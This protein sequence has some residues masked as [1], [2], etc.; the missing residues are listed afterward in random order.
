VKFLYLRHGKTEFSLNNQ[1]MGRCNLP[2][3][4]IDSDEFTDAINLIEEWKPTKVLY[5]PLLRAVETK[6]I[7]LSAIDITQSF[8]CSYL[9]ERDFGSLEGA[10]KNEQNRMR[11][12]SC[13]RAESKSQFRQ[14]IL[15]FLDIIKSET[16]SSILLIGHS[17]FYREMM[18]IINS[19]N[20]GVIDC[21][22]VKEVEFVNI[23]SGS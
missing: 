7:I 19:D 9:I 2:L 4:S 17:S 5:S 13:S 21:C 20:S 10:E 15:D 11:I 3:L 6:N 22:E 12:E 1:F 18:K 8:E 16:D 14:R 23:E